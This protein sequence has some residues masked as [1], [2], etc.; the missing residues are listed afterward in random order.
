[1]TMTVPPEG[2]LTF[3]DAPSAPDLQALSAR[4]AILGAPW[5]VPY[6]MRGIAGGNSDAPRAVRAR[7][8]RHGSFAGHHDFDLD[9]PLFSA[10]G[11]GLVDCGDVAGDHRDIAANGRRVTEAVRLIAGRK[12][13]P[14][15]IG[16]DDSVPALV[17]AG[18]DGRGPLHVVQVDA[19]LD[20]RD[21]VN[22]ERHGYSSPMRRV[23]E[24]AWVERIIHVG[25]RGIG[26]ARPG[27]VADSLA[28]G[29]RIVTARKV[30]RDGIGAA[31]AHVPEGARVFISFDCDG[32]DPSVMPGTGSPLPG[33]LGFYDAVDLFTGLARRGDIAGVAFAEHNP[34]LDVN[35]ITSLGITRLIVNLIGTILKRD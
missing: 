9:A 24:M 8:H 32:L 17:A 11:A 30:A 34:S 16:G 6:G 7:S 15:V 10:A 31:L 21:E 35:A 28:A 13:L 22:G 19:H 5:G 4:F 20:F 33:G 14:I 23:S 1:M 3:L 29:N 2:G 26:S 27:D 12:A 18:L 25:Q